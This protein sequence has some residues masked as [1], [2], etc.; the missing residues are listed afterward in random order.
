VPDE[1]SEEDPEDR[2]RQPREPREVT[3]DARP[4]ALVRRFTPRR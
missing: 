3:A 4:I 1:R 2:E